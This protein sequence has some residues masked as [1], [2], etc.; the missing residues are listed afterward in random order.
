MVVGGG[1]VGS[2]VASHLHQG[3]WH[4]VIVEPRPET[5][6]AAR[7]LGDAVERRVGDVLD[8]DALTSALSGADAVVHAATFPRAPVEDPRHDRT[9]EAFVVR[10]AAAVVSAAQR[11][12]C[13][14]IVLISAA[15]RTRS[16]AGG[17][18]RFLRD[19]RR[20]EQVVLESSV[21]SACLRCTAVYGPGDHGFAQL[22]SLSRLPFLPVIGSGEQLCQ[23]VS[24]ADVGLVA[25]RLC[26]ADAPAGVLEIGGPARMTFSE[27]LRTAMAVGPGV[28]P[29]VHLPTSLVRLAARPLSRLPGRLLTP[30]AVAFGTCD[31]VAAEGR[32]LDLVGG[33]LTPFAS[34]L[35]ESV[36]LHRRLVAA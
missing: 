23:P 5:C 36:E 27:A 11:S 13:S 29:L 15:G 26:E 22:A 4:V 12:G 7:L 34:G 24:S 35:R 16:G 10:G 2:Q 17:S 1:I 25:A 32:S 31:D 18:H 9:F 3:G 30:D 21:S 6:L 33:G 28:R 19:F 20:G 8:P 14:R